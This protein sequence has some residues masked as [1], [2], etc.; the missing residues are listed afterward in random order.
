VDDRPLG[1]DPRFTE[2]SLVFQQLIG[3]TAGTVPKSP[4]NLVQIRSRFREIEPV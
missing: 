2:S 3:E 4:R 1:S